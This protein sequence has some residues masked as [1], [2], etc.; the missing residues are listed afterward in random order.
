MFLSQFNCEACNKK[1]KRHNVASLSPSGSF[2]QMILDLVPMQS[3]MCFKKKK[4]KYLFKV[5]MTRN[6]EKKGKPLKFY[7]PEAWRIL[8]P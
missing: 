2:P 4:K 6:R 7:Y 8:L 1:T 5:M 3:V